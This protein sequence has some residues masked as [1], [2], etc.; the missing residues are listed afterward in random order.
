MMNVKISLSRFRRFALLSAR[1]GVVLAVT[2]CA[3][4]PGQAQART[5]EVGANKEFKMPSE[6]AAKA[7]DGDRIT[8]APGEYFDCA[9][10]KKKNLTIEGTGP[11]VIITDK[12][13]QGKALF[14]V[15]GANTTIRNLTLTRARVPDMNGAGIRMEG[16]NMTVDHVRFINNQDGILTANTGGSLTVLDSEFDRNG[17]CAPTCAHGIYANK[18]DLVHVERSKFT[19]T[20]QGHH[21]KSRAARTEVIDS[22]IADGT[23]GTASY[24]IDIPNGGDV[25]IRGNTM[26]K[27]PMAENHSAA[28]VIGAEG[29]NNRTNEIRVENNTFSNTGSY[30]TLFV[31]NLTA[32]EAEL[33]G[34][35]LS[36]QVKALQ[37]DGSSR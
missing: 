25:L 9:I 16:A 8:I 34:N 18:L 14:V 17:V 10:W 29:V 32:T 22:N 12:I 2:A 26:Q 1:L 28:I 3:A 36:G 13:C 6:A 5:L 19:D 31:R 37:G 30:S 33:K 23:E 20:R 11:G 35:K 24:L 21:I 27:G 4:G 7:E 15:Q